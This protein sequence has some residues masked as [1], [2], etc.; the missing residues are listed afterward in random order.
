MYRLLAFYLC[1]T[2]PDV[3]NKAYGY[4]IRSAAT[5]TELPRKTFP[6]VCPFSQ[7]E[8]LDSKFFP[9]TAEDE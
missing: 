8:I 6:A 4:T 7:D 1:P 5:E 3:I 2:L 9:V